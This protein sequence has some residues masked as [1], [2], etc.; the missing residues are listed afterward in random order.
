MISVVFGLLMLF[1]NP[2]VPQLLELAH[3]V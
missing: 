1:A 2:F 3:H